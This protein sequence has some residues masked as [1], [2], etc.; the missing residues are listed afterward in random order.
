M[1]GCAQQSPGCGAALRGGTA[2]CNCLFVAQRGFA[3][4]ECHP[5]NPRNHARS[6]LR[7]IP[8]YSA[9]GGLVRRRKSIRRRD[10]STRCGEGHHPGGVRCARPG[11]GEQSLPGRWPVSQ[12]LRLSIRRRIPGCHPSRCKRPPRHVRS[13]ERESKAQATHAQETVPV[14]QRRPVSPVSSRH[15]NSQADQAWPTYRRVESKR[16]VPRAH[17]GGRP[18]VPLPHTRSGGR[19]G[20][21][22]DTSTM[23]SIACRCKKRLVDD[24]GCQRTC[25][26]QATQGA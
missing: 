3:W 10:H 16:V 26:G 6:A 14:R 11:G 25:M 23:Q 24:S 17:Q 18:R 2:A 8:R 7:R 9:G 1:E 21:T 4:R 20:C 19:P 12:H 13:R 5:R 22:R 15:I